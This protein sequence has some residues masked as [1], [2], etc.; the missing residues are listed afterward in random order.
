MR[1]TED[2]DLL[3]RIAD[4]YPI[5]QLIGAGIPTALGRR[6]MSAGGLSGNRSRMRLGELYMYK[7]FLMRDVA[8]FSHLPLVA[9]IIL[10]KLILEMLRAINK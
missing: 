10:A 4:T 8:S 6:P 2:H 1:Y 7:K 3:L 9:V 5:H